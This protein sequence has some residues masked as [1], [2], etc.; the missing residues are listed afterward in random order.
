[1]IAE[2]L[3]NNNTLTNITVCDGQK[4]VPEDIALTAINMAKIEGY[5]QAIDDVL[6]LLDKSEAEIYIG[7]FKDIEKLKKWKQ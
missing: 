7:V 3:I 5:N 2:D 1:M 4:V 6:K